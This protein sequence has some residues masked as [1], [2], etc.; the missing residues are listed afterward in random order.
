MAVRYSYVKQ[1]KLKKHQPIF[2]LGKI[3]IMIIDSNDN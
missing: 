1:R 3:I 2:A